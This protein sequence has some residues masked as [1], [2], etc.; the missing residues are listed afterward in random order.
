MAGAKRQ[1]QA[2]SAGFCIRIDKV[3]ALLV[4]VDSMVSLQAA[5]AYCT[6][7]LPEGT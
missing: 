3:P 5:G 7:L 4:L 2:R 6:S 1:V